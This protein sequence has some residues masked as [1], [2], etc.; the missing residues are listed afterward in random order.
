M[1]LHEFITA[2][3]VDIQRGVDAAIKA[4][5]SENLGGGINPVWGSP[6]EAGPADV[7]KVSFDIAVTGS[8]KLS[9]EADGG[10]KVVGIGVG[11]KVVASDENSKISRIQF[12]VPLIPPMTTVK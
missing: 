5:R 2:T 8:E 10:I 1:E 6:N 9:G 12:V 3:L 4:V 7:Q 11:G